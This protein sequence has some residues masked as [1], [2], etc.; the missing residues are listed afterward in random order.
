MGIPS[1][2][3]LVLIFSVCDIGA[4][5]M[6]LLDTNCCTTA[7][8]FRLGVTHPTCLATSFVPADVEPSVTNAQVICFNVGMT[9]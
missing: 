2:R 7:N 3:D 8:A 5:D 6:L 9:Q 4:A 1:D